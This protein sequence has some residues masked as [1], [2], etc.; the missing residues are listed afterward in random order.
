MWNTSRADGATMTGHFQPRG[1]LAGN[2][3]F[4][5]VGTVYVCQGIH[6][7]VLRRFLLV[8]MRSASRLGYSTRLSAQSRVLALLF[9]ALRVVCCWKSMQPCKLE[10]GRCIRE[11]VASES[12][13]LRAPT[14]V[15]RG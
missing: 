8:L 12:P 5:L 3:A 4:Y 2:F 15:S 6:V 13:Q 9:A 10:N 14:E 7:W 1:K 11:R